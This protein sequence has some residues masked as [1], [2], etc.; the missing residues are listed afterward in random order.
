MAVIQLPYFGVF[1]HAD[2]FMGNFLLWL[3]TQKLRGGPSQSGSL[4]LW[5]CVQTNGVFGMK[6]RKI[7]SPQAYRCFWKYLSS[8]PLLLGQ[9]NKIQRKLGGP[10]PA[11]TNAK[12]PLALERLSVRQ[13][14]TNLWCEGPGS[15]YFRLYRPH[16]VSVA[17]LSSCKNILQPLKKK[18]RIHSQLT[19]IRKQYLRWMWQQ[20]ASQPLPEETKKLWSLLQANSICCRD[21]C[22]AASVPDVTGA[23]HKW[24]EAMQKNRIQNQNAGELDLPSK[25][26]VAGHL[27]PPIDILGH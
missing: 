21:Q 5:G 23:Q 7:I 4:G 3:I 20:F 6:E 2:L 9:K 25:P 22:K 27:F 1:P 8:L 15:K 24:S 10:A 17:C 11:K 13:G 18:S 26:L 19:A 14:M 12:M 16:V